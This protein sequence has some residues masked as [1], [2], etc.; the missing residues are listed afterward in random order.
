MKNFVP[1]VLAVFLGLAAVLA[2]GRLLRAQQQPDEDTVEVVASVRTIEEGAEITDDM[3][4]AKRIPLSADPAQSIRWFRRDMV[5]G[6]RALRPVA[7]NDYVLL[8]DVGLSRSLA[9]VVGEGEWAV[10]L[11]L[12][13]GGIGRLVQP[14]DEVAVIGHFSVESRIRSAD[15]AAAQETEQTDATL[16][17]F[18]RVRVLDVGGGTTQ[19]LAGGTEIIL[20]LPPPQAQALLSAYRRGDIEV[21]LRRP[22][23]D[24]GLNRLDAGVVDD[25]TFEDLLQGLEPVAVPLVPDQSGPVSH[26]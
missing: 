3:I 21:A 16:V 2:V 24:S 18:P 25:R 14:G 17:L 15:L 22:N 19:G 13:S 26:P 11:K 12:A 20:A 4:R 8:S 1:L 6:Q 23:D 5:I 7:E 10:S 9:N